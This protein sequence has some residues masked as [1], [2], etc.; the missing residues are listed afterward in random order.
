M[1][2]RF[3]QTSSANRT[4]IGGNPQVLTYPN[5]GMILGGSVQAPAHMMTARGYPIATGTQR[6]QTSL[7]FSAQ[8]PAYGPI[9]MSAPSQVVQPMPPSPGVIRQVSHSQAV[10]R[11]VPQ[12]ASGNPFAF[13]FSPSDSQL[14]RPTVTYVRA[15]EVSPKPVPQTLVTEARSSAVFSDS[16]MSPVHRLS[17]TQTPSAFVTPHRR[18]S[19][20]ESF[21]DG[22]PAVPDYASLAW[23]LPAAD[24]VKRSGAHRKRGST[25]GQEEA[26]GRGVRTSVIMAS[27]T[28]GSLNAPSEHIRSVKDRCQSDME[29]WHRQHLPFK[30]FADQHDREQSA[31]E[32]QWST[33]TKACPGVP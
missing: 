27:L 32:T 5:T 4:V 3:I 21:D 7:G 9:V 17:I 14:L 20:S 22:Q 26:A 16:A 29:F 25:V 13:P 10:S 18:V 23:R 11:Q 12:Q 1:A 24:L 15:P 2:A 31:A 30:R 6:I 8:A 28:D 19:F 33:D